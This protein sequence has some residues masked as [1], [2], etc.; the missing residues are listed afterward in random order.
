M[1]YMASKMSDGK[2]RIEDAEQDWHAIVD[3]CESID[4]VNGE[5]IIFDEKGKKYF[6]GPNQEF[7]EKKLIL[8]LKSV[9]VGK[10]DFEKGE[11]Y[12]I[13]SKEEAS[14]EFKKLLHDWKVNNEPK[15]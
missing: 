12:L 2:Y 4:C 1:Y 11:P 8:G 10:W 14:T 13:D 7:S 6:V 3:S 5:M 15:N 9:N